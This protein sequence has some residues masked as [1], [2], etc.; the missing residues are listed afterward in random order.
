M[1]DYIGST[2]G[3]IAYAGQSNCKEFIVCTE[4]GVRYMLEKENPGKTFYFTETVP[5][6]QD[7][8]QITLEKVLHVLE[9]GENE[10]HMSE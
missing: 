3:I 9:T 7:M 1:S 5:V 2:S 4:E 6:C 10:V 8:K